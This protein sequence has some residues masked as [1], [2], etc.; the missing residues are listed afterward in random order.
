[1]DKILIEGAHYQAH[2]GVSDQERGRKQEIVLD[3]QALVD[4]RRAGRLDDL[5]ASVSYVEIHEVMT[6]TISGKAFRLIEAIA[7][8]VAAAVLQNF[9]AITGVIVRV[10]KP[11]ALADRNVRSTAVEITRMRHE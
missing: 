2:V 11:A 8:D 6:R 3:V 9:P 1:M 7:E 10:D 5:A 4:V